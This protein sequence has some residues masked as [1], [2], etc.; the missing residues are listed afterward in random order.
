[1]TDIA[2]RVAT[3]AGRAVAQARA[4]LGVQG[5]DLLVAALVA[6]PFA[7]CFGIWFNALTWWP[8]PIVWLLTALAQ[9]A[10]TFWIAGRAVAK[11]GIT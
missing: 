4:G 8:N 10:L 5:E 11:G 6:L 1:M 9:A 2:D 3:G 7:G